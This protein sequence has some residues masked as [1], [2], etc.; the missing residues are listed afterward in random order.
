VGEHEALDA[1]KGQGYVCGICKKPETSRSGKPYSDRRHLA[2]DHD[3][4]TG[5]FRGFLCTRC[6]R[7]LGMFEDNIMKL[8]NAIKYLERVRAEMFMT[9]DLT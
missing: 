7:A 6:N 9:C 8:K 5:Q 3:H 1:L 4:K 2:L